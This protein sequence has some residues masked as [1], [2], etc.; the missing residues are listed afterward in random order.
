MTLIDF[1]RVSLLTDFEDGSSY[2]DWTIGVHGI[3]ITFPPPSLLPAGA[4]SP[5]EAPSPF[6]SSRK[7]PTSF[8]FVTY[9]LV[10]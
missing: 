6:A 4:P 3:R 5:S 10:L 9:V 1:L 2:L 8:W 7:C